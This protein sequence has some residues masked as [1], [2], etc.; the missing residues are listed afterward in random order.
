MDLFSLTS[1]IKSSG[2]SQKFAHFGLRRYDPMF[3]NNKFY[4]DSVISSNI[5]RKATQLV[6]QIEAAGKMPNKNPVEELLKT[7]GSK[8]DING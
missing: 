6:A 2:F 5:I 1:G 8:I 4:R 7:R 3:T